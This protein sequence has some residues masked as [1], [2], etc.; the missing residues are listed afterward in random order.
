MEQVVFLIALTSFL[1]ALILLGV[2]IIR[3]GFMPA[4]SLRTRLS[5]LALV[6]MG[7]Y[8]IF[9]IAFLVMVN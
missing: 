7:I 3:I 9:L 2:N 6:F 1:L 8:A 4:L 5:Q